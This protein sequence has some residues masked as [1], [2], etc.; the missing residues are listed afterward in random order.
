M[1]AN[2]QISSSSLASIG[3]GR[4]LLAGAADAWLRVQAEVKRVYGW[5]PTLSTGAT[6]YRSLAQQESIFLQRYT[7]RNTG[8]DRRYWNG[9]YW[10]RKAGYSSA[11]TPGKSNHG[12]GIAVDVSGLGGFS[13]T[14][15]KQ[16]A[17]IASKHGFNNTEGRSI[18][19][20]WHWVYNASNDKGKGTSVM[21]TPA[22]ISAA[23]WGQRYGRTTTSM[24]TVVGLIHSATQGQTFGVLK[25]GRGGKQISAL[26]ELAD[27][28]TL[29]LD[30]QARLIGLQT[31]LDALM[32]VV[33]NMGTAIERIST[34]GEEYDEAKLLSSID[35]I[36][37]EV[38]ANI[39]KAFADGAKFDVEVIVTPAARVE[40]EP[41][42]AGPIDVDS[43][44]DES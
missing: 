14:R 1:V 34:N 37:D 20:A 21:A 35:K 40:E 43:M 18:N 36:R 17:A 23:V 27:A 16:F 3:G 29:G 6:A 25:V 12:L 32:E 33:K 38:N 22:E 10:W 24:H 2:G 42:P 26:Q 19:E 11:A 31:S 44:G 41:T 9:K 7:T 13:G 15:Y 4:Y 5:T 39:D 30:A 8:I 28:K